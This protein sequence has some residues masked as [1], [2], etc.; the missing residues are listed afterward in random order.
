MLKAMVDLLADEHVRNGFI[1]LGVFVAMLSIATA[2]SLA[3]KKQAAD[4]L[5]AS[6]SDLKLQ[7]GAVCIEQ[8]HDSSDKNIRALAAK[9]RMHEDDAKTIRH[10]LNHFE[11]ISVG[12]QNGIYD[13]T[14]I[15][16]SWCGILVRTYEQALPFIQACRQ[17]DGKETLYQEFEWLALRWKKNPLG[18]KSKMG[19]FK[20]TL[21]FW[22]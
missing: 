2:R 17:R 22:Q 13:E 4:L 19:Q 10:I 6:R 18:T 8:H 20:R 3:R 12:I 7:A 15:K 21:F 1:V 16:E 5:F 14:I 11:L 9:D